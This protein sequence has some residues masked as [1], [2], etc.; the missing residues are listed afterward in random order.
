MY[1][2]G[3]PRKLD[4]RLIVTTLLLACGLL[5]IAIG[6]AMAS[7][8]GS[9]ESLV[10]RWV[11]ILAAGSA[12]IVLGLLALRSMQAA[13][14][15]LVATSAIINIPISTGT[16]SSVNTTMLFVAALAG[17]WLLRMVTVDKKMRL[18]PSTLS[19]LLM[20]FLVSASLSWLSGYVVNGG[21]ATLPSNA[22]RVQA[23]QFAMF[24][25]SAGAFLLTANHR[26]SLRT[27]NR[28]TF[29]IIM[30]GS[31]AVAADLIGIY[32]D[33]LPAVTG[34][35][36]MWPF[37]LLTAQLLFNPGLEGKTRVLGWSIIGA[38]AY[39]A[40]LTPIFDWKGGWVPALLAIGLL[41]AFRSIKLIAGLSVASLLIA[42]PTGVIP[43]II[44]S[45]MA[46]GTAYRPWIW[47]DILRMTSRNWLLG[48]G[49]ANYM[50]YWQSL[51]R[52]SATLQEAL[53]RHPLMGPF[54][55]NYIVVPSHNMYVDLIAQTG[56]IGLL[57]FAVFAIVALRLAWRLGHLLRPGFARAH[58]LGVF[59]GFA[60][61]LVGS[62]LFADWLIPFVYNITIS[63]FRHSVYSWLLLGT[64][65][66][67]DRS[68]KEK[69]GGF[70]YGP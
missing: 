47:L 54:W 8:I 7:R 45:E 50:F 60:A 53:S 33:P 20:L 27:I 17:I 40:L 12:G 32:P 15:L 26:I 19:I 36:L 44:A 61:L 3:L 64:L 41:F 51:G 42:I 58:V 18:T 67:I 66:S 13:L 10:P 62:F 68:I 23:G 52:E 28:W 11:L 29:I 16:Q 38:W 46:T 57:L 25:L 2:P 6:S 34:A 24:A 30:L 35:M 5:G 69:N 63:G 55:G 9:M 43:R 21:Q 59:A 56:V 65:V 37:V 49:P 39:W 31:L 22:F 70:E 14:T 1:H 4:S 48:L